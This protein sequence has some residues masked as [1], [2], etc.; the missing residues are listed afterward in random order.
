VPGRGG[1]SS[2]RSRRAGTAPPRR[3][4]FR[5]VRTDA[6]LRTARRVFREYLAWLLAHREVTAFSDAILA[7]GRAD[8]EREIEELPGAYRPPGG[9]L[10]LARIGRTTIGCGAFRRLRP[11]V[12]E[13]KR[14][15]VRPSARGFGFGRRVTRALLARATRLGYRRVVLDTLPTMT[16]AIELY[17]SL[18]FRPVRPYWPHPVPGALFLGRPLPRSRRRGSGRR[19]LTE[20]RGPRSERPPGRARRRRPHPSQ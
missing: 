11:G 19:A 7:R 13:L 5:A 16:A 3:L 1:S 12:A 18:G 2:G 15:Y 20:R 8:L 10:L 4:A 14:I 6:E 17:R 9:D